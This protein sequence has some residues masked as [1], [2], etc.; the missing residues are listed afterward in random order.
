ML[1]NGDE[2]LEALLRALHRK[3]LENDVGLVDRLIELMTGNKG[4]PNDEA[5]FKQLMEK[6]AGRLAGIQ[7][8]WKKRYDSH[9]AKWN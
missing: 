7:G 4:L 5:E 1:G 2:A 9:R 3:D 6:H 8:E